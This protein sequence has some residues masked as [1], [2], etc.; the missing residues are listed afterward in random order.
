MNGLFTK[1]FLIPVKPLTT[2]PGTSES[3]MQ[4]VIKRVNACTDTGGGY[5]GQLYE[6]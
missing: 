6:V 2:A 4:S 1:A 3:V 5:F